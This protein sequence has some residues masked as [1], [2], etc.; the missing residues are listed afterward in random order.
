LPAADEDATARVVDAPLARELARFG[1]PLA[2]GMALQTTF[3]LVDAYLVAQLPH[4]EVGPA[5]GALGICDQIAALG[6]IVSYGVST[7]TSALLSQWQ[8][9]GDSRAVQRAA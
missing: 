1:T 7:A 4:D 5:L 9:A 3:N 2:L 6:T 8:G